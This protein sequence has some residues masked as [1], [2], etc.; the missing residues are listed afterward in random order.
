M[1][2]R[3][4]ELR[5]ALWQWPNVLGLDAP[6]VAMLWQ[7]LL[8]RL[9]S[10]PLRPAGRAALGLTVWAIYLAD[11]ILD[12]RRPSGPHPPVRHRFALR[13]LA[14]MKFFLIV[15]LLSDLLVTLLWLRHSVLLNGLIPLAGV[16]TYLLVVHAAQASVA[17]EPVVA[18]LFTI[19]T[20]LIAWT[21]AAPGA[22]ALL[23]PAFSFFALCLA[24]LVAIEQWESQELRSPQSPPHALTQLLIKALPVW[25]ALL[26]STCWLLGQSPWYRAVAIGAVGIAAI[27]LAQRRLSLELRRTLIDLALC[28]PI[29]VPR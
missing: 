7:D 20:F 27:L 15:V 25:L 4:A 5:I 24:N 28:A 19:G 12:A 9:F 26:A 17:K 21:N 6:I 23:W 3:R 1:Q 11:R 29:L 16:V 2:S 14:P 22:D 10:L 8:A 18:I 13:H